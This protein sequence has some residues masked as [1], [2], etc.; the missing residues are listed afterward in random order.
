MSKSN[1]IS[2]VALTEAIIS[3]IRKH[4]V[5]RT[6]LTQDATVGNNIVNVENAFQFKKDEEI[7]LIDQDYG[8]KNG[9][10]FNVYEYSK[11]KRIVSSTSLELY[12]NL[13][14]NWLVS[15]T[16]AVQKTI[17]HDPLYPNHVYYGDRDVIPTDLMAI[18]VETTSMSNDW[19]YIQ[20]GLSEDY[21]IR[22]VIY[23]KSVK[24]DDGKKILDKYSD[25]VYSLL[26]ENIHLNINDKEVRVLYDISSGDNEIV[27]E[28][29]VDGENLQN[30][31]TNSSEW[32][33]GFYLQ[34]N[35]KAQCFFSILSAD[36]TVPGEIR[37]T[38]D[39]PIG[40]DFNV[41]D[42]A[43]L[44]RKGVYIYDS[45]ATNATFGEVSKSSAVLRASEII[46]FGKVVNEHKFP[47]NSNN[48]KY[49]S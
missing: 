38:I 33:H 21:S 14:G 48:V 19:I 11:V 35:F 9:V 39:R 8:N 29:D 45:R 16:G 13:Q 31:G 17:G 34:D 23:G 6:N 49:L 36:T 10:N 4:I 42:F 12:E 2:T 40:Q 5:A 3:L 1:K 37:L 30:F 44:L 26:N 15:R 43:I 47:Q 46:W 18:T 24:T 22:V 25:A 20:G 28:N 7:V 41:D 32:P 27:I